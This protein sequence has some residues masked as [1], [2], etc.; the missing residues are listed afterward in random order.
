MP[1]DGSATRENILETAERLVIDNG[2]SATSVELVIAESGTSKGAFFHHFASKQALALA[3]VERYASAD[4]DTLA[5]AVAYA[6][7]SYDDPA[8]RVIE[9]VKVY[10]D[11]ADDLMAV[12]SACLYASILAE[13]GLIDSG[14]AAPVAAV[15]QEWRSALAAMLS[16]ALATRN[17]RRRIDTDALTDHFFAT[18]EGAFLICRATGDDSQMRAQITV[19]RQLLEALLALP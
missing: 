16:E 8:E 18:F 10:E 17:P 5:Q 19:L 11:G 9:F 6:E 2:F 14:A 4:L 13:G 7:Q 1:R 12:Q 15:L 3:L